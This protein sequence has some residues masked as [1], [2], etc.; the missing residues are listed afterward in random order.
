MSAEPT[1][2]SLLN[3]FAKRCQLF[4]GI[5]SKNVG[6]QVEQNCRTSSVKKG[7]IILIAYFY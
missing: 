3:N 1:A 2:W 7:K 6:S 4:T 5:V